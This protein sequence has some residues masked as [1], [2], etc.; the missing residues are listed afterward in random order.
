MLAP[1]WLQG[2]VGFELTQFNIEFVLD[3]R[4]VELTDDSAN[5]TEKQKDLCRADAMT[6]F[7][8]SSNKGTDKQQDGNSSRTEGGESFTYRDDVQEMA[9]YLYNKWG[10]SPILAANDEISNASDLW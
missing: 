4:G 3:N 10:E 7:L 8:S 1:N 2:S 5:M 9:I 6:I